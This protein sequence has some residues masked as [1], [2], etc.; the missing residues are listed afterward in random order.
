MLHKFLYMLRSL[1]TYYVLHSHKFLCR[2]MDP[3]FAIKNSLIVL[4]HIKIK[5]IGVGFKLTLISNHV[6]GYVNDLIYKK[7]LNQIQHLFLFYVIIVIYFIKSN[8]KGGCF[9]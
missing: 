3:I 9:V 4:T 8:K 5:I 1:Q 2:S 6:D 7:M